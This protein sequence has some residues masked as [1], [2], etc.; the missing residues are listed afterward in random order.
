M[1]SPTRHNHK[2]ELSATAITPPPSATYPRPTLTTST[3]NKLIVV[4][5]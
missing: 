1:Q 4:G 3:E 2:R 5:R